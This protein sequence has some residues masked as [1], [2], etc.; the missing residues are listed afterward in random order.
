MNNLKMIQTTC[1][2]TRE[3]S[4]TS[5]TA[6]A[7]FFPPKLFPVAENSTVSGQN[8]AINLEK[9]KKGVVTMKLCLS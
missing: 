5:T 8:T 4:S 9:E 1:T 7:N 6:S 2:V 3:Y